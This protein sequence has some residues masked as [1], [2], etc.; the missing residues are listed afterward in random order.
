[1]VEPIG[2]LILIGDRRSV[3]SS[4]SWGPFLNRHQP[5]TPFPG[6]GCRPG[7]ANANG[8]S[9]SKSNGKKAPVCAKLA[10]EVVAVL[11]SVNAGWCACVVPDWHLS[12]ACQVGLRVGRLSVPIRYG[13]LSGSVAQ[14]RQTADKLKQARN[15]FNLQHLL[16]I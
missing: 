1:M 15:L 2:A 14:A 13:L 9:K 8:Q 4:R 7:Q 16:L 3:P 5:W 6:S 11:D 10:V 12:S